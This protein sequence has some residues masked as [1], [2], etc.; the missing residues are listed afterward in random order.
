MP[1]A[2]L[3][4]IPKMRFLNM[5]AERTDCSS[6]RLKY[7]CPVLEGRKLEISPSTVMPKNSPSSRSR[8]REVIWVTE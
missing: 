1:S 6:F 7:R 8:I 2:G 5:T 3:K 4:F